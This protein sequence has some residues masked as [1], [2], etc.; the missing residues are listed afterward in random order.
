MAYGD[1]AY[2]RGREEKHLKKV[3]ADPY[4]R[5]GA[6]PCRRMAGTAKRTGFPLLHQVLKR[7]YFFGGTPVALVNALKKL[8]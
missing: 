3:G 5:E 7:E 4:E 2:E 1:P 6:F 8:L